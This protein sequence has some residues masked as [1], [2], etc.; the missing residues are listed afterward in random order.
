MSLLFPLIAVVFQAASFTLDKV[1]LSLK[2]VT[3][4]MYLGVSFPVGFFITLII[5]WIFKP[6]ISWG[7]FSGAAGALILA[8][9]L[10]TIVTNLLYYRALGHDRLSE[11]QMFDVLHNVPIILFSGIIFA[12]ERN[13]VVLIP[14]CIAT[15]AV[16]WSHWDHHHFH[17][18]KRTLPFVI[19]FLTIAP[20]GAVILK[21]LL[22][23]WNPIS[24]EMVRGALVTLALW[25]FLSRFALRIQKKAFHFLLLGNAL[26][27]IAWI[28]YYFSFQASGVVYTT[29][30]FLL[31]PLLVY[32]SSVFVLREPFHWKKGIAFAIVLISIAAAQIM[33]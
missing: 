2:H 11:L 13:F 29:M 31:L 28:F 32:F 7:L 18:A 26:T 27:S 17:I 5:F 14:A 30:V 12:D 24:L 21:I 33:G 3:F 25:P 9:V 22:Q 23:S 8:S 6:P 16:V 15:A 20:L 1:T 19:W 10:M 4:K